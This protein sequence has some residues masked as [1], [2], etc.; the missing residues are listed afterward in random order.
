MSA[1]GIGS[2]KSMREHGTMI[3]KD[4]EALAVEND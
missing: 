1:T 2:E 4:I 3:F